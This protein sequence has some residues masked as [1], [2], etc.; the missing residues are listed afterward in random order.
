[1]L[2]ALALTRGDR[3]RRVLTDERLTSAGPVEGGP[4]CHAVDPA[5]PRYPTEAVARLARIGDLA[6][7][8]F[9]TILVG[10]ALLGLLGA[11]PGLGW[12]FGVV[13]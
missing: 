13:V 4:P 2:L 9:R 6:P 12:V 7:R 5:A 1:M 3:R 10:M 8:K 11:V